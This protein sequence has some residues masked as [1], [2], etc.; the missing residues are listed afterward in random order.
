MKGGSFKAG[1]DGES[2]GRAAMG[3]NAASLERSEDFP[4]WPTEG[5]EKC[6]RR[7]PSGML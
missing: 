1:L 3:T 6:T 4:S 5:K 2:K 7:S